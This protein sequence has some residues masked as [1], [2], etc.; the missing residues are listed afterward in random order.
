VPGVGETVRV[1]GRA[2]ISVDPDLLQRLAM[3][4]KPPRCVLVVS[5]DAVFFQCARAMKR[6]NLWGTQAQTRVPTAGE[7]LATLTN[8]GIDGKAY[9][10]ALPERQRSTLY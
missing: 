2:R 9:D 4:G 3:D 10:L 1:N 6:S 8:D 7:M 5:V